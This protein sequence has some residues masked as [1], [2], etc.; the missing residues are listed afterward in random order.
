M[1]DINYKDEAHCTKCKGT[2]T[3][4]S[5]GFTADSG[6]VYPDRTLNCSYCFGRG[7]FPAVDITAIIDAVMAGKGEKRRFRKAWPEKFNVWRNQDSTIRRA[8]YIWRLARFHGGADVTLPMTAMDVI[9]GDPHHKVLDAMADQVAKRVFGTD[10]A[11]AHR[12]GLAMGVTNTHTPGLPASAYPGG[13]VLTSGEKPEFEL[14]E[15]K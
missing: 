8:Y 6:K 4:F 10:R 14:L 2:G 9:G 5:K 11:A 3:R 13:P 1:T 7:S 15:L 12:W